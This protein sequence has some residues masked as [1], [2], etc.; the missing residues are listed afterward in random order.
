MIDQNFITYCTL[1]TS[2]T[3]TLNISE[4]MAHKHNYISSCLKNHQPIT[5]RAFLTFLL[6]NNAYYSFSYNCLSYKG[7]CFSTE[8]DEV[9]LIDSAFTWANTLEGRD[10]WSNLHNSWKN[11]SKYLEY[12]RNKL[13]NAI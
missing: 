7:Y 5:R 3:N 11:I 13:K 10:F 8:D 2:E 9:F 1:R 4:K 6:K 12:Y